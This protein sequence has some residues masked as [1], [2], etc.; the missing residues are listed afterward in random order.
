MR[1]ERQTMSVNI[2][3][4]MVHFRQHHHQRW[5]VGLASQA[6]GRRRAAKVTGSRCRRHDS[7]PCRLAAA[8]GPSGPVPRSG[9]RRASPRQQQDGSVREREAQLDQ[10]TALPDQCLHSAEADVRPLRRKSG[11]DPEWTLAARVD[12]AHPD[13]RLRSSGMIDAETEAAKCNA[14]HF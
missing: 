5:L 10:R 13:A 12:K 2:V 4:R 8:A 9:T 7:T 1:R 14:E 3:Q 6:A 11:F